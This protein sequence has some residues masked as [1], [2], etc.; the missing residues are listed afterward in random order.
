MRKAEINAKVNQDQIALDTQLA[1]VSLTDERLQQLAF[2]ED[3][4]ATPNNQARMTL[5]YTQ[6]IAEA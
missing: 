5:D 6:R 3:M 2:K 1:R 4:V